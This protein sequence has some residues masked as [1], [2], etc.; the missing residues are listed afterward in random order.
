MA[1]E[2]SLFGFTIKRK[3]PIENKKA[4]T[5]SS[6]DE[7]GAYQISP[8]GGYFGQYLDINGD[9]F[10]NDVDLI[11]KYRQIT[12]Y[13]EID[14]AIEDIVNEAITKPDLT[15]IVELNLDSLEQ[16]DNVKDL[17]QEE[18]IKVI[19][20]L[21]FNN[22]GYDLFR[23]W[24]TDGR[25]FFHVIINESKTDAGI[26]ELKSIDPTKIRKVKEV[27]KVKDP[28]TG[29]E[30]IRTVGEYYL[31]QDDKMNNVGEGLKISTDSIIQV[32]SGIL[33]ESRDKVIG[34]LHKALK[35]MNQLSMMEDSMVIYRISRA[36]ERRIFY[37]D[38][39]NLPKG[40]AEEYLNNVMNKYRNKVVYDPTTGEIKDERQH[41][42]VMEDFWLPR[43]EGGRGTEITTLPG[44]TNL[45][46]TED[47]E[48]FKKKLY[49]ALNVP[50]SRLESDSAFSVGRSSEITRDE[51]KFQK[52]IDRIRNKFNGLF[53]QA[54]ERQLI[55]KKIIVPS[56]WV[57]I[58]SQ[59]IIEYNKDNYYAELKD[60]EI[61]KDRIEMVQMMD[62][63]IGT[64]WSKDWVRRNILKLSDDDMKQIAKDNKKD[65]VT[66][67]DFN[68]D[69]MRSTN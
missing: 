63:Y 59:I 21:D 58:K 45:G 48:Y 9:Q 11:L 19:Q 6:E 3:T 42:S 17:I 51:L 49:R 16:P 69:L 23:R 1:E 68:P 26:R 13:P 66:D 34:Y 52:F 44:G 7:D 24:Y 35:P 15:G 20:I 43:R 40:K 62:E 18:F 39:G 56:D 50:M 2:R 37:I 61:L 57:E 53:F 41:K 47:V 8:T 27:E 46:E 36:P 14:A 60:A 10:K 65:P 31:F 38:V 5:F 55:L 67:K 54:L 29:A 33:N 12:S 30:L 22:K 64:F 25:L 32:N 4:K 28:K